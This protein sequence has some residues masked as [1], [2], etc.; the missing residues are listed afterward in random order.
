MIAEVVCSGWYCQPV[1][2]LHLDADAVGV[3]Q[4]GH[5]GVVLEV[6]AGRVA[7][8]V[9]A[10]AVLLAEQAGERRAVLVGEAP[11]LADAVVPQLGE[12]LGHLDAEAVQ[13]QVLLVRS[14]ANSS[15]VRS[16]T[17]APIVTMWNAA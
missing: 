12:R 13:Q 3:E 15:A 16:L 8:R 11:L 10:A 5:R 14:A 17:A 7:P 6:G 1:S 9:A 2:S 4:L